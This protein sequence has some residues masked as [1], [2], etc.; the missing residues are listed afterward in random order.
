LARAKELYERGLTSNAQIKEQERIFREFE[1]KA[2][3]QNAFDKKAFDQKVKEK[4]PEPKEKELEQKYKETEQKY[5]EM[6]VELEKANGE[7]DKGLERQLKDV[8]RDYE[9]SK[10]RLTPP[11]DPKLFADAVLEPVASRP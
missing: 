8:S 2:L 7:R 4:M 9:K 3:E 10:L 5:K 11:Q 6:L 1:Q